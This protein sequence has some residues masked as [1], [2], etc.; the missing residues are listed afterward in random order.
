[1][2][3][4]LLIENG[5]I[6]NTVV[7]DGGPEWMLPTGVTAVAL[8]T[9]SNAGIGWAASQTGGTWTFVPPVAP[10]QNVTFG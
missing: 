2:E 8:P 9:G 6:V 5:A 7:W 10:N 3:T 1:M 4:Y